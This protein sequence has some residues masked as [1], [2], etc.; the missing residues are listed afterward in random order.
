MLSKHQ[1]KGCNKTPFYPNVGKHVQLLMYP[2]F[3]YVQETKKLKHMLT[4]E[5]STFHLPIKSQTKI[6]Q[7]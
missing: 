7:E 5:K 6:D 3:K 4:D 2:N 1:H